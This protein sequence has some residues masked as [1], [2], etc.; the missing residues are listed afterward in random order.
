[1]PNELLQNALFKRRGD[2]STAD[3]WESAP[4][5]SNAD[6]TAH[7]AQLNF[8]A[9]ASDAW[10]QSLDDPLT[11]MEEDGLE[12]ALSE[13]IAARGEGGPD[14][15]PKPI[16]AEEKARLQ[17]LADALAKM[18]K[19]FL[20]E[21]EA[22]GEA[23]EELARRESELKAREAAVEA[24]REALNQRQKASEDCP[25]PSWLD[26][27]NGTINIGITGNAG[28][29]KS[30]L[31]NKL[32]RVRQGSENWAPT[33]VN[34]TTMRP[35]EYKFPSEP[36]VR[37]WDLPGAGTASFPSET[38]IQ[39]MGLRYFDMIIIATAGRYTST[40][41]RLREELEKHKVVYFMVRT[42]V[43]I[44]AW[45]NKLDNNFEPEQTLDV[46]RKDFQDSH[47]IKF[48]YLVSSRDPE[49]YDMPKL[50]KDLF[51]GLKRELDPNAPDYI[52]GWSTEAWHMP[53]AYSNVLTG[54]QG[55][56]QDAFGTRYIINGYYA[57]VTL[58]ER[59]SAVLNLRDSPSDDSVWW[60]DR[61]WINSSSV[62]RARATSELRWFPAN[63]ADKPLVWWW[64]D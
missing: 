48:C 10:L 51:P 57:H 45:N 53:M 18:K 62:A 41:I 30:L 12:E 29:G 6:A 14:H 31:I 21:R 33:G 46:I 9:P 1:M 47:G 44:D 23:R 60:C 19:E 3:V 27:V 4:T 61:W 38:Y 7:L 34:E 17:E 32:R 52:P 5:E 13:Q 63:I 26:N 40:E 15:A 28:V 42:K 55:R 11:M 25:Q 35:T 37:L 59:Q 24:E 58:R 16:S 2:E 50:M 39:D 56:W 20:S 64:S 36:R 8:N 54:I 43:D 49:K 22:M